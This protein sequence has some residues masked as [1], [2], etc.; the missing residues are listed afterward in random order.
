MVARWPG[1]TADIWVH[2]Q[3]GGVDH[4]VRAEQS[5]NL[6]VQYGALDL[7]SGEKIR[8]GIRHSLS[9][10]H[11]PGEEGNLPPTRDQGKNDRACRPSRTEDDRFTRSRFPVHLDTRQ[12][13]DE[14]RRVAVVTHDATFASVDQIY[15][16]DCTRC[17]TQLVAQTQYSLFVGD[18][19][20]EPVQSFFA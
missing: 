3:R 10:F 17:G 4:Q 1:R 5:E 8:E 9:L 18:G 6:I 15:S 11:A 19:H 16:A 14:T 7:L 13:G 12:S 20:I 2:S